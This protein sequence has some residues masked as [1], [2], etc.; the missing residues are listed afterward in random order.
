MADIA[1]GADVLMRLLPLLGFRPFYERKSSPRDIV[2]H[3][4][5]TK[6]VVLTL[7]KLVLLLAGTGRGGTPNTVN[8]VTVFP[9][10]FRGAIDVH[11][12]KAITEE[13]KVAAVYAISELEQRPCVP[14]ILSGCV[15]IRVLRRAPRW[16]VLWK[17][18]L[19]R[20]LK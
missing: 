11:A 5:S 10:V 9:G 7:S 19:T 3:L 8:N 13:M 18:A 20:H 2:L 4:P 15:L 12:C 16:P 6:L 17:Q 14:I 1:K